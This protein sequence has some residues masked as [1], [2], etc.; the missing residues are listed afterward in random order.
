MLWFG[1][2]AI[3]AWYIYIYILSVVKFTLN[4]ELVFI[5]LDHFK[6]TVSVCVFFRVRDI[7]NGSD[8]KPLEY[9]LYTLCC[10]WWCCYC[11]CWFCNLLLRSIS[12]VTVPHFASPHRPHFAIFIHFSPVHFDFT[13]VVS[14]YR[15]DDD[16]NFITCSYFAINVLRTNN[17]SSVDSQITNLKK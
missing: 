8:D 7:L 3:S 1:F 5:P 17:F 9:L 4:T 6:C 16:C 12:H 11:C 15:C 2:Y 13:S 14:S 10:W